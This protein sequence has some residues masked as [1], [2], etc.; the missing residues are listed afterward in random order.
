MAYTGLQNETT[1]LSSYEELMKKAKVS[2]SG[3]PAHK[4]D[5]EAQDYLDVSTGREWKWWAGAWH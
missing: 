1:R 2:G 3:E 4:P 5:L